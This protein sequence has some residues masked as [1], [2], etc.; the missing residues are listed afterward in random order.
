MLKK[1]FDFFVFTSLFIALCAVLMVYQTTYIF[2]VRLSVDL[3]G[4]VFFGSVC[5]YNFHWFLTPPLVNTTSV[6]TRWNINYRYVHLGLFIIS[7]IGS[8]YF[9][10]KLLDHW[11]WLGVTAFLTFMYSA[12]KLSHPFFIGLRK[13]AIGK[14]I[15]LAFA[16]THITSLLPLLVS[17]VSIQ[18][19]HIWFVVNRFFYLYAICIIFDRRD[20]EEDKKSGIKSLI[21]YLDLKGIDLLFWGSLLIFLVTTLVLSKNLSIDIILGLLLPGIILSLLYEPSKRT[22][23]DYLYYFVLDGMM[24]ISAPLML[25]FKFV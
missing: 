24:M 10:F 3:V 4:F 20:R 11:I 9:T 16:W 14:T 23:S 6:K 8:A 2:N 18:P 5:S 22:A 19:V 1:I 21:T 17:N 7:L 12:P 15:F 25:L 13:I